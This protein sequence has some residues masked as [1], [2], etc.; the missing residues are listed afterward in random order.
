MHKQITILFA[1]FLPTLI[2][3]VSSAKLRHSP[4][5]KRSTSP[6]CVNKR[7]SKETRPYTPK[8]YKDH[9]LKDSM[10]EL[11]RKARGF[12][13][14]PYYFHRV[15]PAASA[16][17]MKR[18]NMNAVV[19]DVKDDWGRILYPSKI[20]LTKG[21]QKH[22]IKD[23]VDALKVLHENGIY[24][25]ARVVSFKDS[26]LPYKRP[27]LAVR[28]GRKARRLF[29]AGANW[30]DAYSA[31]VQDY[32]IDIALELEALGFDEIQFDYIR[33]PKGRIT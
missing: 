19:L 31:E 5:H 33:F 23:P 16:R 30:I 27:D 17:V 32:L 14:T 6:G 21:H 8:T 12:Y 29:S 15:G 7:H 13:L 22:L 18:A 4:C 24:A 25:I 11:G 26:R 20:P 28:I 3:N 10:S 9:G 2:P 1:L